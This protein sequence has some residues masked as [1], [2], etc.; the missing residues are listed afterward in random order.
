MYSTEHFEPFP[1]Q[2][3]NSLSIPS[4]A[5]SLHSIRTALPLQLVFPYHLQLSPFQYRIATNPNES[6]S[7]L[8]NHPR[9]LHLRIL[10]HSRALPQNPSPFP[11]LLHLDK[12]LSFLHSLPPV[13]FLPR[14]LFRFLPLLLLLQT[15]PRR[16]CSETQCL[17]VESH[18]LAVTPT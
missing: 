9:L 17:E 6:H 5:P 10:S 18:S 2:A 15:C 7:V 8:S 13:P 12:T 3:K 1:P 14:W 11:S 16:V 4:F